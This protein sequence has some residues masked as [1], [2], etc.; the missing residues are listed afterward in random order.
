[1]IKAPGNHN[2]TK[3]LKALSSLKSEIALYE[4]T[5]IKNP[6]SK[7]AKDPLLKSYFEEFDD[8]FDALITRVKNNNY[9]R[10]AMN[11]S[12]ICMVFNKMHMNNGTLDLTDMMFSWKM[13]TTMTMNMLNAGNTKGAYNNLNIVKMVYEKM[14]RLKEKRIDQAFNMQFEKVNTLYENW[15]SAMKNKNVNKA[16]SNFA[17]FD[18]NF[19]KAFVMSL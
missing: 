10:A 16:K 8:I 4:N 12:R 19:G 3:I 14:L 6:P 17:K 13:Q 18:K 5:Y 9:K 11:C 2:S 7:Y 1:M 15:Y